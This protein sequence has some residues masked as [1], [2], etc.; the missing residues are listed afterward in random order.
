MKTRYRQVNGPHIYQ[1]RKDLETFSQ[2]TLSIEVYYVK[3]MSLWLE[4]IEYTPT[5]KCSCG[6]SKE[7]IELFDSQFVMILFMGLNEAY[8]SF[9]AQILLMNPIPDINKVISLVIQEERQKAIGKTPSTES[10]AL[11]VAI[12]NSKRNSNDRSKRRD[13]QRSPPI[14]SHCGIKGHVVDRCYKLHGYPPGYK[15]GNSN[16]AQN[17]KP[18]AEVDKQPEN[19]GKPNQSA[20]FASLSADQYS[21]LMSMLQSHLGSSTSPNTQKAEVNHITSTCLSINSS[22]DTGFLQ[23][24]VID[25]GASSHI[26]CNQT[27]FVN[28]RPAMNTIL[29]LC[30]IRRNFL[31]NMLGM[32]KLGMILY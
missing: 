24:W 27:L 18:V 10:L 11:S 1:L 2:G 3:I 30:L 28:L 7:L 15:F 8:S 32:L 12:D 26:C 29:L 6:G 17:P 13:G 14:Y 5:D 16:S 21:Q 4:L 20:F 31:S 9:R 23:A 19:S 25:S 22:N